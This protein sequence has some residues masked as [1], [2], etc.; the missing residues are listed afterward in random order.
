LK[1]ICNDR[2]GDDQKEENDPRSRRVDVKDE[3]EKRL[4][5]GK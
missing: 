5:E 1:A 2:T 4:I 3:E